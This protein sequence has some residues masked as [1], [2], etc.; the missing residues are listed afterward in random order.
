M[1]HLA[2]FAP[3]M[4]A[5]GVLRGGARLPRAAAANH[6]RLATQ[7]ATTCWRLYADA[8]TGLTAICTSPH[9]QRVAR[10]SHTRELEY[11]ALR[12]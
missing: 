12:D 1:E 6:T 9:T 8:P 10:R 11:P 5:L 4:L 7:L 2:C 3:G